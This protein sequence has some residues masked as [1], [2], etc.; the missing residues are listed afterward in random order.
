MDLGAKRRWARRFMMKTY[1]NPKYLYFFSLGN[2]FEALLLFSQLMMFMYW[3]K[4]RGVAGCQ[5][6]S[7]MYRRA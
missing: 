2:M 3:C 6:S 1:Y 5:L 7:P 4:V